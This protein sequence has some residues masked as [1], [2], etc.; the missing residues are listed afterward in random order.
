MAAV[1]AEVTW[2]VRLLEE[3]RASNL[4]PVT[5]FCYNQSAFYIARNLVFHERTKH[6]DID[7]HFT[8]DKVLEGLLQLS[9]LLTT[10]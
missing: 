9:Y 6:I 2:V 5:L 4:K 1:V 10:S 3:L 8:M 7:C